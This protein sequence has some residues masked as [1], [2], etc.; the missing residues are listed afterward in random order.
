[1]IATPSVPRSSASVAAL[2]MLAGLGLV[3]WSLTGLGVLVPQTSSGTAA[4]AA[5]A[6]PYLGGGFSG[7]GSG[8]SGGSS[9]G[10]AGGGF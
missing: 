7:G 10:G 9:S 4:P 2:I 6:T 5:P 3:Y 1:M 8:S